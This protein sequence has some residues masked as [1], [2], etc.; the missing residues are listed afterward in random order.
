MKPI[1]IRLGQA[2]SLNKDNSKAL[3]VTHDSLLK[4]NSN[5]IV[6]IV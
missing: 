1:K 3:T 6:S 5:Y 2:W 4:L